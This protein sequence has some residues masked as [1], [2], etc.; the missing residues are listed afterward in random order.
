MIR[1]IQTVI[2]KTDNAF[3]RVYLGLRGER[4]ALVPFLFHS[5]FRNEREIASNLVDPLQRTTVAQFHQFVEYYISHGYTFVSPSDILKGL[6][7]DRKYAAITFDDGYYNNTL[8]LPILEEF[9]VPAVFF[10]SAN[11]VRDGKSYWWDA[12]HRE[13]SAR[14]ATAEEIYDD[15]IAMKSLTTEAMEA[16]LVRRFGVDV[17]RPRGDIDRPFTPVELQKFADHPLV[18]IGNHTA[19][20]A[21]LTNYALEDVRKQVADAQAML[22]EMTGRTPISIA[23]PNGDYSDDVVRVCQEVGIRIG[24]TVRPE[25]TPLG[26]GGSD[27]MR[28]GRFCPHG[29]ERMLTQCRTYRSDVQLYGL[30]R[31][32]YVRLRNRGAAAAR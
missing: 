18:H 17:L 32:S 12:L 31:N 28:V 10:I 7:P 16:A 22:T 13:L 19:N 26:A 24:F 20:H 9:N 21:I 6:S 11:H 25:K 5:L 2:R 23:Y 4:N 8:A 3:A 27:L 14:G 29:E 1:V 30:L 15:A